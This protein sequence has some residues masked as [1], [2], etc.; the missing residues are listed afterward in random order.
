MRMILEG[1]EVCHKNRVIHRNICAESV[2]LNGLIGEG[3]PI[4]SKFGKMIVKKPILLVHDT[5]GYFR[6]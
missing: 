4:L 5:K 2:L 6:Y 3:Y 1:L